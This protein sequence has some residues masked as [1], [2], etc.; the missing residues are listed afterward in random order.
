MDETPKQLVG[1]TK[2]KIKMES[3]QPEKHD[4]EYK[5]N[6][7]C[8][9]FMAVEPLIGKRFTKVTQYKRNSDWTYFIKEI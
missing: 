5:K 1:E 7:V 9:I 2:E 3:G 4:Y 6:G 8:N